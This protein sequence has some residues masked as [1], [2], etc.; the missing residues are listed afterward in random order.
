MSA[1]L[2]GIGMASCFMAYVVAFYYNVIIGW[3]FFYLFS[4][5]SSSP[6]PWTSCSNDWNSDKCWEGGWM[7]INDSMA[8]RTYNKN[9]SVSSTLE[10]FE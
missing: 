4:S 2:S 9:T 5:C 1:L 8:N 3:S 7:L 10:F 6:L